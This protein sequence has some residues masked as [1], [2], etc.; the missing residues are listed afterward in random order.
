MKWKN[1]SWITL[2]LILVCVALAITGTYAA[3]TNVEYLKR[4]VSSKASSETFLFSSNYLFLR[5]AD[6]NVYPLRIIP[7]GAETDASVTVTI[8]NYLQSDL[9]K[10]SGETINYTLHTQLVDLNNQPITAD[11]EIVYQGTNGTTTVTGRALAQMIGI[12]TTRSDSTAGSAT[13]IGF[14]ENCHL[15]DG[16]T[17]AGETAQTVY[18]QIACSQESIPIL[19]AIAIRMWAIPTGR[20]SKGLFGQL[21]LGSGFQRETPWS[22]NFMSLT[23]N[24]TQLDAFNYVISGTVKQTMWL[25]WDESQVTL[26]KWSLEQLGKQHKDIE[27]IGTSNWKYIQI[28]VGSADAPSRYTLQFYRVNGALK[29]ETK[30]GVESCV[31]FRDTPPPYG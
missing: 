9:T 18:Y 3:Y 7:V 14:D 26:G 1:K 25:S 13:S 2:W 20:A 31:V 27:R 29:D 12:S 17:L 30:A 23:E 5:N 22:G 19:N 4:V 8:C 28:E 16:Q 10:V 15:T 21:S 11:T 24:N 6:E